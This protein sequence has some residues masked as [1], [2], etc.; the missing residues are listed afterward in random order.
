MLP[1]WKGGGATAVEPDKEQESPLDGTQWRWGRELTAYRPLELAGNLPEKSVPWP[2][3]KRTEG[4]LCAAL[5]IYGCIRLSEW[6]PV[7]GTL[8]SVSWGSFD[9]LNRML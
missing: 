2:G 7:R 5:S 8:L 6:L 1:V 3:S 9:S 4:K